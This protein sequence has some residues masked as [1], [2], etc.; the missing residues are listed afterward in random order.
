M[1]K[2]RVA[3]V[4]LHFS[5]YAVSLALALGKHC[6]VFLVVY[7]SN[8]ENEL[9]INWLDRLSGGNV[10]VLVLEQPKS[11][12]SVLTNT[13]K[14]VS[15]I[16]RFK[17]NVIHYQEGLRDEMALSLPFIFRI[18]L[19]LTVH[20][21]SA[22]SGMDSMRLRFSRYRFYRFIIRR[23]ARVA[24]TH[25][26]L[27]SAELENICPWLKGNTVAIPHGP[28]GNCGHLD[29]STQPKNM[30]L[31][32][33]GRIH[34]YK[35]LRFFV[36]AVIKLRAEGFLV[37]GI[38]AGRGGDL[39]RYRKRMDE[40]GCFQIIEQFIPASDVPS[41]FLQSQVVVLP[42]IDGTQ[43]GVAALALGFERPI[44]ASAVGSIPELVRHGKNGL[45][46][47]PQNTTELVAAIRSILT[48]N[49]LWT[50]LSSGARNLREGELSWDC[51]SR[52]TLGL[53]ESLYK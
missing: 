20:D 24:I 33:F 52:S 44:V 43:S 9:G 28:L 14:I 45:L 21:P 15:R 25:G 39:D 51:I 27:L 46:V 30:N 35:G 11:L 12:L 53:Y 7:K 36:D 50:D 4:S 17:A 18:P 40:A 41:L 48:N 2:L 1:T 5:E 32:F 8:S 42:Y 38:V 47:A 3:L 49:A 29:F 31:L 10:S 22:H 6:D 37:S 26:A 23:A 13:Y 16:N 19:I 34:E